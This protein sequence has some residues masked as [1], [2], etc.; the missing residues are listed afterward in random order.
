MTAQKQ[1]YRLPERGLIAGVLAG[2][3]EYLEIDTAL[4]RILFVILVFLTGIFPGIFIYIIAAIVMPTPHGS[5][6]NVDVEANINRT[7]DNVKT[8]TDEIR[9]EVA[10]RESTATARK[11]FGWAIIA[12]GGWHLLSELFPAIAGPAWSTIWPLVLIALGVY[13]VTRQR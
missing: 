12:I 7:A 10:A 5:S 13:V 8:V 1:L 2:V 9:G 3:A 11:V 4:T 6:T